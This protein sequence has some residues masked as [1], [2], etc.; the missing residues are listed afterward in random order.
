MPAPAS[1]AFDGRLRP[2]PMRRF[3][4]SGRTIRSQAG[5]GPAATVRASVTPAQQGFRADNLLTAQID[6]RL[7]VQ[8]KLPALDRL[9]QLRHCPFNWLGSAHDRPL[10]A[11]SSRVTDRT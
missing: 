7:V 8:L 9:R 5:T 1:R 6:N 10:K 11:R 3:P 4:A 2:A